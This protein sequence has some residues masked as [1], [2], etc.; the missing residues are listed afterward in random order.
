M[1]FHLGEDYADYMNAVFPGE[2]STFHEVSMV[3]SSDTPPR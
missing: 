3:I 1:A 2:A